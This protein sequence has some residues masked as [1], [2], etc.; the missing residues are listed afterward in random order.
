MNNI[1]ITEKRQ[2]MKDLKPSI[3]YVLALLLV[4]LVFMV[5][6]DYGVSWDD[7]VHAFYGK[8]VLNFY[9]SIFK[10]RSCMHYGLLM[11]YGGLFDMISAMIAPL[12]CGYF[13]TRHLLNAL[14]GV[15]GIVGA[16]K[17]AKLL[18]GFGAALLASVLLFLEPSYFGHMFINPKDIP[19]AAGY[20]FSLYYIVKAMDHWPRLP[21]G[22]VV[23]LGLAIGCT[24]GVRVGGILLLCYFFATAFAYA[25]Y[26]VS[27]MLRTE[28]TESPPWVKP[29]L[30][31]LAETSVIALTVMFISWPWVQQKPFINPFEALMVA[32]KFPWNGAVL[33]AGKI[34]PAMILPS[35]YILEYFM[36]KTSELVLLGLC[37]G[38][39]MAIWH[40][41]NNK[42]LENKI[43]TLRYVFICFVAIFPVAYSILTHMILYDAHRHLLFVLPLLCVISGAALWK[44]IN[45]SIIKHFHIGV[46]IATIICLL[47]LRQA[48]YNIRLHP[49]EYIYY[50]VLTGGVQGANGRYEKDYWGLSF[51]EASEALADR[52]KMDGDNNNGKKFNIFI[53]GPS[54]S[55]SYYLPSSNFTVVKNIN[56]ADFLMM[57]DRPAILGDFPSLKKIV[58]VEKMGVRLSEVQDLRGYK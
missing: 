57:L 38:C 53:N 18:G 19:L 10:D 8:C 1:L 28:E 42:L 48:Y 50:N 30:V 41:F 34:V 32:N 13:E 35:S 27:L 6:K 40:L 43:I 12:R 29:V 33:L 17:L 22:L 46:V 44:L 49:Y 23:K 47:I 25:A 2:G 26:R 16:W 36:V 20:V 4:V 51:K 39:L 54:T 31:S 11:Y 5:F 3:E 45:I 21:K 15:I 14:V 37:V 9:K 52:L 55:A 58:S 56:E 7:P 24:L